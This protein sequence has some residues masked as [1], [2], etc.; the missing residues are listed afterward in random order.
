MLD[1]LKLQSGTFTGKN[2]NFEHE[3]LYIRVEDF[4]HTK[5][6]HRVHRIYFMIFYKGKDALDQ[7]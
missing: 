1:F 4:L 7:V 6:S 2:K 3:I 5:S